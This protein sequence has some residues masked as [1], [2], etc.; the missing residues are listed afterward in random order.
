MDAKQMRRNV[1]LNTAGNLIFFACQYL[2]NL[3]VVWLGGYEDAGYL[4]TAMTVANVALSFSCYGMRTYQVSDLAGTYSDHTYLQSRGITIMA[5]MVLC[6]GFVAVNDYS[7]LQSWIILA[8]TAYRLI[9]ADVDVWHGFLQK[10][11]RMD[12]VGISFG[13]RGILSAVSFSAGLFITKNLLITI[14]LMLALNLA[15]AVL[16]DR[17][18]GAACADLNAVGQKGVFSLLWVCAPLAVYSFL[19]TAIGSVPKYYCER[20]L[21]T[22]SMGYFNSI[23]AP[24]AIIQVGATYLFVPF[25]TTFARLWNEKNTRGFLKG[26]AVAA[27]LLAALCAVGMPAVAL[28]GEFALSILYYGRPEILEYAGLLYPLVAATCLTTFALILCHL[29]TIMRKMHALIIGNL[30]GIAASV[31]ASPFLIE[32]FGLQGTALANLAAVGV[33]AAVLLCFLLAGCKKAAGGAEQP[34]EE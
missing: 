26:V 27:G 7:A 11:E 3:L 18:Q 25:I 20:L 17:R 13:V 4:A 33:Q 16:A 12:L 1:V 10:A 22:V 6:G 32:H 8:Y 19:N 2:T 24:V 14:C 9:E 5:A 15:Y 31:L 23:F 30:C 21:G 34:A 29:L 28:L